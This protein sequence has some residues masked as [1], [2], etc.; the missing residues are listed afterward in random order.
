[1]AGMDLAIEREQGDALAAQASD[2]F[3]WQIDD[4]T[5]HEEANR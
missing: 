3:N 2:W 5:H 4:L 1:M